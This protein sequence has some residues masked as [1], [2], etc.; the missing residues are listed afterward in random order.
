MPARTSSTKRRRLLGVL[1]AGAAAPLVLWS[2]VPLGAV[3]AD[4]SQV[5]ER[6]N[7]SKA[8]ESSLRTSAAKLQRLENIAEKGIAVLEKRQAAAQAELTRWETKL[9]ST[10]TRLAASRTR[11]ANEKRRLVKD[12]VVLARNLRAAYQ[13]G[14]AP[15]LATM[16]VEAGGVAQF[17]ERLDYQGS[18]RKANARVLD[19]VREARSETNKIERSLQKVVP[20]QRRETAQVK[21]ERDA[22]ASRTA[23]LTERRAALAQA[24]AARLAALRATVK[25]RARAQRTLKRLIAAEQKASV[26]KSGPGGPWAIPWAI[27]Q[28]ESGGQNLPPNSAGASGYYQFM[29]ATW[30]GMGGSTSD[31][32]KAGKAE[33]DRLA[34]KLWAGGAGARNWDCAAIVGLI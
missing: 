2:T 11:L 22:V 25:D 24:R 6:I 7:K 14:G 1:V 9:A 10:E 17:L 32:Y 33:Q 3:G 20:E 12:R 5:Q 26:D 8:T 13:G 18:A 15:D 28:C 21:A 29:P 23:A 30:K 27:V 34:A 19:N 16:L 4:K 31:A